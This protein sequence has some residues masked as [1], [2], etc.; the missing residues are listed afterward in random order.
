MPLN[1]DIEQGGSPI[2]F[3]TASELATL[4]V[5]IVSLIALHADLMNR[6]IELERAA[7]TK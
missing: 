3:D 5:Q 6:V 7:S 4:R 2:Q 1:P